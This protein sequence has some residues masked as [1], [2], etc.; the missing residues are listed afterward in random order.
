MNTVVAQRILRERLAK[1][2]SLSYAELVARMESVLTEEVP[3]DS[4]R[5]WQLEFEVLWDDEPSG[6]VRVLG[7]ID[8]GGLRTFVPLT[9]SFIKAPSGEFVGE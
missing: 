2:R 3:R 5:S 4:E 9:E 7:S 8:D 6:N 1:L